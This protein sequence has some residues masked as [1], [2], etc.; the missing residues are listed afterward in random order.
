MFKF[1]IALA[2]VL[3]LACFGLTFYGYQVTPQ[4]IV[5]YLPRKSGASEIVF[6]NGVSMQGEIISETAEVIRIN[7]DGVISD[8]PRSQIQETRSAGKG[9][10]EDYMKRVR[11]ANRSHPLISKKKGVSA[12]ARAD[13]GTNE[14]LKTLMQADKLEQMEKLKKSVSALQE[15]ADE[16]GKQIESLMTP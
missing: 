10:I 13:K 14:T 8:F 5:Y 16:R 12:A 1:I 3:A 7:A 2:A 4:N 11:S 15:K 6:K 9:L